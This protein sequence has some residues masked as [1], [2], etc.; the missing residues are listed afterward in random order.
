LRLPLQLPLPA[1]ILL[2]EHVGMER[3]KG[4]EETASKE[5]ESHR[6]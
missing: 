2:A 1:A 5:I 3:S 6:S 4:L